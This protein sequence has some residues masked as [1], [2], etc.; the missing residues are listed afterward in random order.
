M[1]TTDWIGFIGVALLLGAYFLNL[2]GKMSKTSP[3]YLWLNTIG[4]ALSCLASVLLHYI[5][6]VLLEAVWALVSLF[7]LVQ[8]YMKKAQ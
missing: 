3:L 5:P 6:F 8:L 2:L 1:T 7:A 4:A